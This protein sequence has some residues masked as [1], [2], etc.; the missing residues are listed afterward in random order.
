VRIM[1]ATTGYRM[2]IPVRFIKATWY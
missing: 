2:D 1:G